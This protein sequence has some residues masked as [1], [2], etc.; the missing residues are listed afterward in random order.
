MSDELCFIDGCSWSVNNTFLFPAILSKVDSNNKPVYT[1]GRYA[2]GVFHY[3]VSEYNKLVK[4]SKPQNSVE[5]SYSDIQDKF[6]VEKK[7]AITV[8][9]KLL[10]V[11]LIIKVKKNTG[12]SKSR[13]KP[14]VELINNLLKEYI[15]KNQTDML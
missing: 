12:R 5:L 14:N 9:K 3:I 4:L 10:E 11:G 8:I 2:L 1:M 13:Y 7:T 6:N 15:E